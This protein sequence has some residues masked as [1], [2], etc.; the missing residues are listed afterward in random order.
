[1]LLA[2]HSLVRMLLSNRTD[3]KSERGT[4]GSSRAIPH[5]NQSVAG[6]KLPTINAD[7][8]GVGR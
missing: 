5:R 2:C 6:R 8:N 3:E 1:M 7:P 4:N